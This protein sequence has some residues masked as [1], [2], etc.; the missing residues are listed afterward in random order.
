MTCKDRRVH[1]LPEATA[2]RATCTR[3]GATFDMLA[4]VVAFTAPQLR[5]NAT[6][7]VVNL[8]V[9]GTFTSTIAGACPRCLGD[10]A[11]PVVQ[12]TDDEGRA[13]WVTSTDLRVLVEI[14]QSLS[15][16]P[17]DPV[18]A[19][20]LIEEKAPALKPLSDWLRSN[21]HLPGWLALVIVILE[22]VISLTAGSDHGYRAVTP[23]QVETIIT[24]VI[25]QSKHTMETPASAPHR[26]QGRAPAR[27]EPCP[28]GSGTKYKRCHGAPVSS[29]TTS[30]RSSPAP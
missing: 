18:A 20:R 3:C 29:Q 10:A 5:D 9:E 27:N 14:R 7:E 16:L 8:D 22:H 19:A 28:C 6:G 23:A 25:E 2:V 13:A 1:N 26:R 30:P 4:P 24:R 15:E 17:R 21:A 12:V 11:L